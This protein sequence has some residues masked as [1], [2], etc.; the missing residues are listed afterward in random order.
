[1]KHRCL[2]LLLWL[3]CLSPLAAQHELRVDGELL[4]HGVNRTGQVPPAL[5]SLLQGR[6]LSVTQATAF[7][8]GQCVPPSRMMQRRKASRRYRSSSAITTVAPLLA[9]IR[10]QQ[11]PYNMLCPRWT[12]DDGS[13][14]EE[15]CLSGCVATCIEQIM[16]YYRYPE[17]LLD[18]LHG[19]STPHYTIDDLLPGTR[20]DWDHYLL[21]YRDGW[22]EAQGQAI[23]LVSLACGMAV[24]MNYGLSSSGANTSRAVE[25]LRKAFGYGMVTFAE[26]ISYSPEQWHA[27]I[28]HELA[29]GRPVAY[30]GHNMA[31]SGH[32]FNID[33]VDA[34]GY[35]H[36]NWGYNGCYDGWFDLDWL[37][38]WEPT[39]RDPQGIAEGMFCNQA[40]LMMHPSAEAKPLDVD[41]LDIDNLGITLRDVTF[42]RQPDLQDY[43]PADFRF[44]ND[45]DAPVTYTYEVMTY[46]PTDTAIFEQADYVGLSAITLQPREE[47]V[48]RVYLNFDEKG[49]RILGISHDDVTIPFTRPVTIAQGVA[50]KLEWGSAELTLTKMATG[51]YEATVSISVANRAAAGYAGSLVTLCLCPDGLEDE[52]LRHWWVL[53]L[54][55]GQEEVRTVTFSHL[56]PDT[57][58][59]FRL[60][61][62]WQV[63]SE[64][65]FWTKTTDDAIHD[66]VERDGLDADGTSPMAHTFDIAGRR[67]GNTARGLVIQKGKKWML[68]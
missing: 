3:V 37:N 26:R 24:H 66:I 52:D 43:V 31:L 51:E 54:P 49:E 13:V 38:P 46:L 44:Y 47:K 36:V 20:F 14:S 50:P 55:G 2:F 8:S 32:A 39:D 17:V 18:T 40:L 63:Q 68:R 48:Q 15:R 59:H 53:A 10:D 7:R 4:A 6:R 61:C 11:E 58:Y 29:C 45:G 23:A 42:L 21:D 16:A 12:Y 25:P 27:L 67:L 35:Y 57:Y 5:R 1:M 65:R 56:Q 19:W 64:L 28:Q 9:S 41:T 30:T 33:G 60:R 34:Q 22:T 62:P